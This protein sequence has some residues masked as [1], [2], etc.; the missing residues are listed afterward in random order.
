MAREKRSGDRGHP[1]LVPRC[2]GKGSAL[3]PAYLIWAVG[4]VCK[5]PN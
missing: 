3:Y 2:M 5:E 1:C 4:K